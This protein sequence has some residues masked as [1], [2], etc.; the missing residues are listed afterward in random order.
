[1]PAT[2]KPAGPVN[3]VEHGDGEPVVLLHGLGGDVGFWEAELAALSDRFRTIAIDLRGDSMD[4]L[5]DDVAVVLDDLGIAR[6]HIVGF[7]LGGC[8]AQAFALRHPARLDR[9]VLASTFAVMNAQARLFLD[10]VAAT[11]ARTASAKEL[12]EL[13]CP[14]LF[15]IPFLE[16]PGNA[17][18]LRYD[19]ETI[20]RDEQLAWSWLYAAQRGFD[21]RT[22]I[23]GITSP[24]LVIAGAHDSLV[25]LDDA[26]Y[27]R[28]HIPGA[29]LEVIEGAGHLTNV[30]QPERFVRAVLEHLT[31]T[32]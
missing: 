22:A 18:Y 24:T 5:A 19:D 8:A 27:L 12:F 29:T 11:Y 6:T 2:T 21:A 32:E 1:M 25:S 23:G 14:W 3:R 17:A 26:E 10:A 4:D 20:D 7:S 16:D 15:S 31:R 9:L 28:D 13:V 30:E